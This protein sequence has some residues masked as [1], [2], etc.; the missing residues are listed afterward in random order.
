MMV[1]DETV[2]LIIVLVKQ[3]VDLWGTYPTP[4]QILTQLRGQFPSVS[5]PP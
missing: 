3:H 1:D 2:R 4:T 5:A